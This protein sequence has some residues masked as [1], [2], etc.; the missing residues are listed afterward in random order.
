MVSPFRP[1]LAPCAHLILHLLVARYAGLRLEKG[2]SLPISRDVIDR[3]S[4]GSTSM[5]YAGEQGCFS[6]A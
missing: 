5:P 4:T 1:T 2:V 6:L 3:L